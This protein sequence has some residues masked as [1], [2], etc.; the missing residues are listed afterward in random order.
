MITGFEHATFD[1]SAVASNVGSMMVDFIDKVIKSDWCE[2]FGSSSLGGEICFPKSNR[3][4]KCFK[5]L[6]SEAG[7][8]TFKIYCGRFL[9]CHWI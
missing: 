5:T 3:G 4:N 6:F 9:F 2:V 7:K 8:S 1:R